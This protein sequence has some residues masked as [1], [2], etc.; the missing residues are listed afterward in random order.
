M[1]KDGRRGAQQLNILVILYA[2]MSFTRTECICKLSLPQKARA[3]HYSSLTQQ[4]CPHRLCRTRGT[5]KMQ[6]A[7]KSALDSTVVCTHATASWSPV[8]TNQSNK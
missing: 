8:R 1:G 5:H 4:R 7:G 6:P 2:V 3:S